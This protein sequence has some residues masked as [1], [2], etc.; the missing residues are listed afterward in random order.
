[1]TDSDKAYN[2][3]FAKRIKKLR[4]DR[5]LTPDQFVNYLN[6]KGLKISRTSLARYEAQLSTPTSPTLQKLSHIFGISTDY[7]LADTDLSQ[8]YQNITKT[9]HSNYFSKNYVNDN[10]QREIKSWIDDPFS[11]SSVIDPFTKRKLSDPSHLYMD[12]DGVIKPENKNHPITKEIT[13][14]WQSMFNFLYNDIQVTY[15]LNS[16][17]SF[18][19]EDLL[20]EKIQTHK[21]LIDNDN[22]IQALLDS[23]ENIAKYTKST[24]SDYKNGLQPYSAIVDATHTAIKQLNSLYDSLKS[25]LDQSEKFKDKK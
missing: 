21:Y 16:K 5:G 24:I 10:L 4:L 1:M 22:L 14:F 18:S 17:E 12:K 25:G 11:Q 7:F 13:L 23:T 15:F 9:L 20:A 6:S 2:Q 8:T 3:L 19:F